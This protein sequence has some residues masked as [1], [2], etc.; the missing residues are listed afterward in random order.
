MNT[1]PRSVKHFIFKCALY[2]LMGVR[3]SQSDIHWIKFPLSNFYVNCCDF[4]LGFI[5]SQKITKN[6]ICEEY[7]NNLNCKSDFLS[8][9]KL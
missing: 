6:L 3:I 5:P 4:S 1:F 9:K 2:F 7:N 8:A